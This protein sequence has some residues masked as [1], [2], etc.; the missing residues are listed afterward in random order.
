MIVLETE[1]LLFRDHLAEDLEPFCELEADPEVR[2][3]VGGSPRT[4]ERA[5]EKFRDFLLPVQDRLGL[6][7]THYKPD[8]RYIGYC[9][10][11]PHFGVK[12]P[13]PFEGALGYTLARSHWGRGLASEAARAFVDFGFDELHLRRIVAMVEVGNGASVRVL[14]KLGFRLWHLET[15][16]RRSFYHF[17]LRPDS[18]RRPLPR[19]A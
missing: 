1:R 10:V 11:Y 4:R 7:A 17:E 13:I 12:G 15:I 2:R 19:P 5:E 18:P 3:F 16:H 14:E 6:W 9:G 8:D